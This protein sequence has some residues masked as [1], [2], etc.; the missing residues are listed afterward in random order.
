MD[1]GQLTCSYRFSMA[2]L[3]CES[4][5]R[6]P[7]TQVGEAR[8]EDMSASKDLQGGWQGLF[9]VVDVTLGYSKVSGQHTQLLQP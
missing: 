8:A 5:C 6:P 9:D 1:V 7:H 3:T 2:V 4:I